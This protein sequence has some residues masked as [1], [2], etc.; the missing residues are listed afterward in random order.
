MRPSLTP[1]R[2]GFT[3]SQL[4][5]L[6]AILALLLGFLLSAVSKVRRAAGRSVSQNN[7]KQIILGT[8]NFADTQNGKMP[9]GPA[10]FF[11][12]EKVPQGA[13]YGPILFQILPYLEQNPLYMS[14]QTKAGEKTFYANWAVAGKAV[15]T[16]VA[17]EDPAGD[18]KADRTSYLANELALPASGARYPAFYADGTSNTIFFAE[19]YS[20]ASDTV[21]FGG[22]ATTWKTERRWWDN[23]T[24]QPMPGAVMF[25]VAPPR[26]SASVFLPQ[27]LT[28]D[29]INVGLGDGS[30]RN[31]S[32]R[33]SSETFYAA[34][35]PN[36]N[37]V[38]GNDW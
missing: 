15:R 5:V 7:M 29:G 27:A 16:Y 38:L 8:I 2:R 17:P 19:A 37:E 31:L 6:L 1:W 13:A 35:T 28:P 24:W 10:N 30:V 32:P 33:I 3:L 9:P 36:G 34:C 11:P 4:L 26:D 21:T 20:Q 23:P 25:Q 22:K 14:S 12:D 18:P